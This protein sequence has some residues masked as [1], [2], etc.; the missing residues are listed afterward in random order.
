MTT[1]DKEGETTPLVDVHFKS[2]NLKFRIVG[3]ACAFAPLVF[4]GISSAFA[5]LPRGYVTQ[6]ELN[7]WKHL[8]QL[9]LIVPIVLAKK[10]DLRVRREFLPHLCLCCGSLVCVWF[11]S[12][13]D[14]L[15]IS[16]KSKITTW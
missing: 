10:L 5:N 1:F 13:I 14:P 3:H 2:I 9:I 6:F 16:Y 12:Y 7:S 15:L 4:T 8:I 11:F